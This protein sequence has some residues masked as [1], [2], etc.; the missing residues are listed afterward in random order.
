MGS[1]G[2]ILGGLLSGVGAG[3]QTDITQRRTAALEA[4]KAQQESDLEDKKLAAASAQQTQHDKDSGDN[5]IRLVGANL[6]ADNAKND[7]A[8][9]ND[10]TKIGVQGGQTRLTAQQ[11]SALDLARDSQLATLKAQLLMQTDAA[12]LTLA[13]S[14]NS[15][16][17]AG[18][19][20]GADGK[21]YVV[22]KK[23]DTIDTGIVTAR[24]GEKKTGGDDPFAALMAAKAGGSVAP[25][26][27]PSPV[28]STG[29]PSPG[30]LL[31]TSS[32]TPMGN[33][34]AGLQVGQT[35][36]KTGANGKIERMRW[37]GQVWVPI[38]Q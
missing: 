5:A 27:A 21:V 38:L 29:I 13:N 34:A 33:Q 18:T 31:G 8:T 32:S 16:D 26:G 35:V 24:P 23:G 2:F 12:S 36:S 28:P 37:N 17:Y 11:Q 14:L 30:G 10:I 6:A 15:E 9:G 20:T 3:L 25:G 1:G 4:L 7:H 19:E 22:T